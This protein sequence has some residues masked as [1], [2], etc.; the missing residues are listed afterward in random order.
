M[1]PGQLYDIQC[2]PTAIYLAEV[3]V[4]YWRKAAKFETDVEER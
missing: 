3:T 2:T 1:E 4:K